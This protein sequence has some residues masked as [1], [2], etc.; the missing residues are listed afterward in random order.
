MVGW[1]VYR[2]F[3]SEEIMIIVKNLVDI[4]RRKS[5][6]TNSPEESEKGHKKINTNPMTLNSNQSTNK[7]TCKII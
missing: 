4:M 3:L 7:D 2:L 6:S 5:N 1:E